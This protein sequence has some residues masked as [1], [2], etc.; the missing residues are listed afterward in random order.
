MRSTVDR[1][2]CPR[3]GVDDDKVID[4]RSVDDGRAIRR[5]RS[6]LD[7]AHR[8]TTFERIET[9]ELVVV[10][11]SGDRM[12]FDPMRIVAGARAACKN[13]PVDE[14]DLFDLAVHIEEVIRAEGLGVVS[15]ERI[16]IEVLEGL[17]ELDQV[18]YLRFASVYKEFTD[19]A[20]FAR[21]ARLLTKATSP[22]THDA[23]SR[24]PARSAA[25]SR[26]IT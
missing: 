25:E 3:C 23:A 20:D 18:A 1:V 24:A 7:C 10:K 14:P 8:F 15:T 2:Q 19:A 4:S 13:R 21:E 26:P 12:P 5:R 16:G 11:R 17:R 6:C 9:A 22:K